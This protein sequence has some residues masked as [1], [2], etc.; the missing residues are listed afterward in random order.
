MS[1]ARLRS[2]IPQLVARDLARRTLAVPGDLPLSEAVRRAQEARAGGILTTT[3]DGR[4]TGLVSEAALLATPEDRRPWVPTSSVARTLEEGLRL[5]VGLRGEDL[6][7]ALTRTPA[8]EYLLVEED[9][10]V[11]GVLVTADVDRA[12]R[13]TSA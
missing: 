5:S 8:A 13:Q 2:R 7:R 3:T 6:V 4:T 11:Y 10:S 12:F 1:A 9:G